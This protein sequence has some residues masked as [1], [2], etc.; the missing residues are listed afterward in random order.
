MQRTRM[1]CFENLKT[2]ENQLLRLRGYAGNLQDVQAYQSMAD[3]LN[4]II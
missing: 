4:F 1:I 3:K 2:S